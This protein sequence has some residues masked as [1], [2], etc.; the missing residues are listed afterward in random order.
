MRVDPGNNPADLR[1][2]LNAA[3]ADPASMLDLPPGHLDMTLRLARR[4]KLLGRLASTL[5]ERKSFDA[6]PEVAS[7]QL[8]SA[9]AM[10]KARERLA[11][12]ELDRIACA[13]DGGASLRLVT[14]K[15]C[16]YLLLGLPNAGGRIFADVDL[17]TS[18]DDLENVEANLNAAGWRSQEL[19]PYDDNYYRRWTHELPPLIHREREVEIDLHH[20]IL[21]RTARLKPSSARLLERAKPL[22][23]SRYSVLANEDIVLHAMVHLLF[24]S[25]LADKLRD[26]L[27]IKLLLAHFAAEDAGFW[28]AL[29]DRADELGLTRPCYYS[30]HFCQRLLDAEIPDEVQETTGRWAP[31][32]P[33][34]WLMDRLVPRAL[35]PQLP[36]HPSRLTGFFRLLL[37]IRSHWTRM[38]PWLLVY[39]LS[40]KF[41]VTR[42]PGF[43]RYRH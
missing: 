36:D 33:A 29:T 27:D 10:A 26:L 20:N 40:Y 2:L 23:N 22:E 43:S 5:K 38:P 37:Y 17:M 15:G 9:L 4:G 41:V 42:L 24:D 16:T 8:Q 32:G 18:E 11:L 13:V 12:W 25:D 19:N 35:Y 7:D 34:R 31:W 30:I 3:L 28:Q 1:Q 39:H 6:L 21:P 14:M